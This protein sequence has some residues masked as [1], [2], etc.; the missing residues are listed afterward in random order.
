[1]IPTLIVVAAIY[2]VIN[3]LLTL[4]ARSLGAAAEVGPARAAGGQPVDPMLNPAL[5]PR[6][7]DAGGR[8]GSLTGDAS[9][10]TGRSRWPGTRGPPRP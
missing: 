4:L 10:V 2:I 8:Q 3:Y 6:G 9:G 1:M 7:A 5:P